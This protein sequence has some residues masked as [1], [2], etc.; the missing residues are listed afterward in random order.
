MKFFTSYHLLLSYLALSQKLKQDP[1]FGKI[2]PTHVKYQSTNHFTSDNSLVIKKK[3]PNRLTILRDSVF[4]ISWGKKKLLKK[5]TK[6]VLG[7][8]VGNKQI[9]LKPLFHFLNQ[10]DSQ[11]YQKL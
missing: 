3:W 4:Q 1:D 8:S 10:N 5:K 7:L 9:N 2:V 11:A 6:P